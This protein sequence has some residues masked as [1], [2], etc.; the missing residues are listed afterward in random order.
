MAEVSE[1]KVD[2]IVS[3]LSS[4]FVT[5]S[6]LVSLSLP[7]KIDTDDLYYAKRFIELVLDAA[8]SRARIREA[9]IALAAN[10]PIDA[11]YQVEL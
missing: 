6:G 3:E 8:N 11:E 2:L 9:A 4:T 10:P 5:A 7:E 1:M